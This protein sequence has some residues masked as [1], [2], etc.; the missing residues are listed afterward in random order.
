MN[1]WIK[2]VAALSFV[3]AQLLI[4]P[5][6]SASSLE[7]IQNK[8]SSVEEE[9]HQLQKE[10]NVGLEEV[11][12]ISIALNELNNEIAE[13]RQN[14][15]DTEK[16][17]KA[18][19]VVVEERFEYTAEQLQALQKNEVNNNIILSIMQAE[20]FSELI[21]K[22]YSAS[23]LTSASEERL[24]EAQEE[25]EKLDN[26][27]ETLLVEK[28]SLDAKQVEVAKQK[29]D[30]DEKVAALQTTLAAN[31]EE[32]EQLN[33]QEEEIV[34]AI[35]ER[36]AAK[37]RAEE[38]RVAAQEAAQEKAAAERA[39][40]E[41]A[42]EEKAEETST[43]VATASSN[44]KA[45]S[46]PAAKSKNSSSSNSSKKSSSNESSN[47][48]KANNEQS[49]KD[50]SSAG[51]WMTFQATGYSTQQPGLSTHTRTGIDL[52]VNPRVIA[53]DPSVIPLNSM[54][55]V[56]GLGVYIAGDTGGAINGRIIDIHYPTVSEA[57]SWGRRNVRIRILN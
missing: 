23:I 3:V 39:A 18:Q 16:D 1:K 51:E 13:H 37:K 20:S 4:V 46:K 8:K 54:V 48:S 21:N 35:A 19:E 53:V 28:E 24:A 40:T 36:E 41:R 2:K 12:E 47:E 7:E 55:E 56:E 5:N 33:A 15:S 11:S 42:Q 10:V 38:E 26:L 6:V 34:K 30:L 32:L 50:D 9:V 44:K 31:T 52:R 45:E 14:I 22:I 29:E 17:I 43:K 27:R 57:L 49:A 25:Q